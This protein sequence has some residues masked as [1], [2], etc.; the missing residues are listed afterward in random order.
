MLNAA[1]RAQGEERKQLLR[2]LDQHLKLLDQQHRQLLERY[3]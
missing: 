3:A 2:K 1:D